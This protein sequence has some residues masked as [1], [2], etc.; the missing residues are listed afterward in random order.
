MRGVRREGVTEAAGKLQHEGLINYSRGQIT[1]LD[2]PPVVNE[3][4]GAASCRLRGAHHLAQAG[5]RSNPEDRQVSTRSIGYTD[6]CDLK[7]RCAYVPT[8]EAS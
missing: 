4:D 8:I 6:R 1:V 7:A 5:D 2:F 3:F